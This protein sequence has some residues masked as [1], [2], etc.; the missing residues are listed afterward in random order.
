[1]CFQVTRGE[2]TTSS[3]AKIKFVTDTVFLNEYQN[4][5]ILEQC[6][7]VIVDEAQE[8][9]IDTDIVLGLMKECLRKR[10]DLKLIVMF[11]TLDTRLFYD[12]FASNFTCEILEVDGTTYPIEDIYLNVDDE[13]YVQAAVTKAI[14]IHQN[15]EVG[16]ILVFLTDQD[17]IDLALDALNKKLKNDSSFISLPLHEELSEEETAQ[18][19]EKLPD[20]R[21]IIFSTDIAE[22]SI[23]IDGIKYVID[24]GMIK[25]KLWDGQRKIQV[26]NIGQI[27][28]NSVQRRRGTAGIISS[29]K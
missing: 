3:R 6:S 29:G 5:P 13:N 19:F 15:E 27:T 4:S 26:L 23:T 8:R 24:S 18:L 21:K 14:E 9:T 28:K 17:E 2:P 10:K 16:D 20:K 11:A 25:E 12:Y 7:V 1:V 22:S